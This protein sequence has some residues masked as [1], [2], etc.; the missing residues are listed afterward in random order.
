MLLWQY[1]MLDG[2]LGYCL[3]RVCDVNF[4]LRT[5]HPTFGGRDEGGLSKEEDSNNLGEDIVWVHFTAPTQSR[6]GS[7]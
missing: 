3:S 2:W 7:C 6:W 5:V 4:A 1:Q